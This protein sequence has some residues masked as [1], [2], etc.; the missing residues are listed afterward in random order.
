M[1]PRGENGGEA[2]PASCSYDEFRLRADFTT[3]ASLHNLNEKVVRRA[4]DCGAYARRRQ[5]LNR[6]AF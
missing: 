3:P 6:A 5:R 1:L 4:E 2:G